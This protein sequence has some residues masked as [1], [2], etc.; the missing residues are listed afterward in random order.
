MLLHVSWSLNF[1]LFLLVFFLRLYSSFSMPISYGNYSSSNSFFL[2]LHFLQ[3]FSL[4]FLLRLHSSSCLFILYLI[5]FF[6][7]LFLSLLFAF[8]YWD[9]P[10]EVDS[11]A[12]DQEIPRCCFKVY[13]CAHKSLPL[14]TVRSQMSP[15][16][17]LTATVYLYPGFQVVVF[18]QVLRPNVWVSLFTVNDIRRA[19]LTALITL[20]D[21]HSNSQ[22]WG[23]DLPVYRL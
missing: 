23:T 7:L 16:H 13:C 2:V 10:W 15:V 12:A 11:P 22:T 20:C 14:D 1:L 4:P 17:T 18:L 8:L 6:V 3:F 21:A 19:H 5:F 9:S